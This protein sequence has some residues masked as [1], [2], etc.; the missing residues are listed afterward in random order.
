MTRKI[1]EIT[2][3]HIFVNNM[4]QVDEHVI[5]YC[6]SYK[7]LFS[8]YKTHT[9]SIQKQIRSLISLEVS[10]MSITTHVEKKTF[11]GVKNF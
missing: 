3:R 5:P 9:V 10:E 2:M 4:S 8:S 7:N 1:F 11:E 6:D